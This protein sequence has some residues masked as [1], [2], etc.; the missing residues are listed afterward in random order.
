MSKLIWLM[1]FTAVV[2]GITSCAKGISPFEAAN[3]R[4]K[5]GRY[6]K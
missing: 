6:I 5:C 3:G 1:V 4:A 2:F